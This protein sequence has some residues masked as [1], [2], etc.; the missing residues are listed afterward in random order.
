MG[1]PFWFKRLGGTVAI[2]AVGMFGS[3]GGWGIPIAPSTLM[4]T[5]GG[6]RPSPAT[7]PGNCPIGNC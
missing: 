4:V 2:S 3:G 5:V 6:S 1:N 7:W